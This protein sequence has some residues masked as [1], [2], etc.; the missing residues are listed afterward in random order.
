MEQI[1]SEKLT[2]LQLVKK[3]L[4]L[5]GTRNFITVFT[6]ACHLSL[7]WASSIYYKPKIHRI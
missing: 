7:S 1:A 4:T 2:G 6:S 3:F 5:Y